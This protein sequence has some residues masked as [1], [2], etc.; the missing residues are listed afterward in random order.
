MEL[1]TVHEENPCGDR[2]TDL[3]L[4]PWLVLRQRVRQLLERVL[5]SLCKESTKLLRLFAV[6]I[7]KSDEADPG[8]RF[9]NGSKVKDRPRLRGCLDKRKSPGK[10]GWPDRHHPPGVI[11]QNRIFDRCFIP[12]FSLGIVVRS[13]FAPDPE[14]DVGQRS[15]PRLKALGRAKSLPDIVDAG[16]DFYFGDLSVVIGCRRRHAGDSNGKSKRGDT[17]HDVTPKGY[18][19]RHR[20]LVRATRAQPGDFRVRTVDGR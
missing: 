20:R 17:G 5:V 8:S 6:G 18:A 4:L 11:R 2:G 15:S 14:I 16:I 10:L 9:S 1:D 7:A 19:W 13:P 12:Q 3:L